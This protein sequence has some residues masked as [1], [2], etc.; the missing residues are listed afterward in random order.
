LGVARDADA[1]REWLLRAAK[2]G[3]PSAEADLGLM[4]WQAAGDDAGKK[5]AAMAMIDTAAAA[6][7][8]VGNYYLATIE[9]GAG[10][11]QPATVH[12]LIAREKA[13]GE[14]KP[15]VAAAAT[16]RLQFL[17]HQM[18]PEEALKTVAE[19]RK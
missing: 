4:N 17:L 10:Q 18:S 11:R 9:E 15:G 6:G 7:D 16:S 5:A 8:G 12:Y 3:L 14:E 19:A 2:A 1:S 13:L